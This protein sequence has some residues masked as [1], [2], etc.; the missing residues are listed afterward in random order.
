MLDL[1]EK[2]L[3]QIAVTIEKRTE[4][5]RFV[6]IASWRN[7]PCA[8]LSRKGSDPIGVIAAIGAGKL[9]VLPKRADRHDLCYLDAMEIRDA[10]V[11]DAEAA[12]EVTRRSITELCVADHKNDAAALARWLGNKTRDSF[13]GW[14]T[15]QNNSFLVAVEEGVI[16]GVGALTSTGEIT[17]NYVSPDARFRGISRALLGALEGRA[18]QQGNARCTLTSTKTA[19]RFYRDRGYTD[20]KSVRTKIN[21]SGH[22]MSKLLAL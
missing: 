19:Y 6:A 14:M 20:D 17:L 5:D 7:G 2:P 10:T 4:A 12:C 13:A 18:R 3:D 22:P 11:Q 1:V 9:V 8:F 21:T 16:V 15:H